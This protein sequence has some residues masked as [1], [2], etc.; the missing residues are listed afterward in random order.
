MSE[1][2]TTE[3][4]MWD[5]V[6]GSEQESYAVFDAIQKGLATHMRESVMGFQRGWHPLDTLT[7]TLDREKGEVVLSKPD[8]E[9]VSPEAQRKEWL[10]RGHADAAVEYYMGSAAPRSPGSPTE[11]GWYI[12]CEHCE[13]VPLPGPGFSGRSEAMVVAEA[14]VRSVHQ[15]TDPV[16]HKGQG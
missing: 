8:P 6:Q 13:T 4:W 15:I 5:E 12:E 14:H 7:F 2:N 9:P 10:A 3:V 1:I 16:I 11:R